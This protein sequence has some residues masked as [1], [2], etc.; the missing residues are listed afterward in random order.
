MTGALHQQSFRDLVGNLADAW[1]TQDIDRLLSCMSADTF[2]DDPAMEEPARGRQAVRNFALSIW[3]AFPDLKYVPLGE[4]YLSSDGTK[5]AQHWKMTGTWLGPYPPGF[6]PTGRRF[7]VDG[8]DIIEFQDEKVHH[9]ITRFDGI[10][11]AEQLG[12]LPPRLV[13]GQ[14]KTRVAI[15]FQRLVAWYLRR[16]SRRSEGPGNQI[17]EKG[18]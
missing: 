18:P 5:I 16:F 10:T 7:E 2:W 17:S 3:R 15:L 8:V 14:R 1:N 13:A 6:A 12:L 4:P 11:L 9:C